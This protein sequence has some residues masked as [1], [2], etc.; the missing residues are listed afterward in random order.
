MLN[1][2]P[3]QPVCFERTEEFLH[4]VKRGS[5][6]DFQ[7]IHPQ[8]TD[9]FVVEPHSTRRQSDDALTM[10]CASSSHRHSIVTRKLLVFNDLQPCDD[11]DDG[12]DENFFRS[13]I[14][15]WGIQVN[16]SHRSEISL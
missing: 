14:T 2:K 6:G 16:Q 13:L 12:D 7:S 11:D 1:P 10:N 15:I 5:S 9:S 8:S 4:L 3:S